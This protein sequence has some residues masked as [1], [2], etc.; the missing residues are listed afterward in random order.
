VPVT[1][2]DRALR[3]PM[4]ESLAHDYRLCILHLYHFVF[5][6]GVKSKVVLRVR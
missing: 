5:L 4:L 3:V 1:V 2:S 6:L